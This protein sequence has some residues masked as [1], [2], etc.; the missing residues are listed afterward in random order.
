MSAMNTFSALRRRV[1]STP[2]AA[3][4]W[5]LALS[6]TSTVADAQLRIEIRRGVE[7]PVPI[8]IVPFSWEATP[9]TPLPVDV[10]GVVT[11]DLA[12][13]G[14]FDPLP[15]RDMVSRPNLP[16]QVDIQD[17]Q[18]LEVDVLVIGRV[19]QEGPNRYTVVF[20]LYDILR[21]EQLVGYRLTTSGEELRFTAHRV[22]DMI[23]EELT[24]IP[25]VFSTR[26]AYISEQRQNGT[27]RFRLIVADADGENA[28]IVADSPDPLMSPAW[29]PD[30][31]QLAYVSFEG[32]QAAIYVQTLRTGVR[33]RVSAREGVNGAP[34]F[35]PDGRRLALTLSRDA[36]NL[37][38]FMLDLTTQV[39]IRLTNNPAIDTEP[40]WA[41]DGDSVFFTSDRSGGPQIYRVDARAGA[42]AERVTFEGSYNARARLSPDG[43]QLAVVHRD[44]GNYRIAVVDPRNGL[45][46]VLTS[47]ALDESPSF[48]PNGA[49]I[50]YATRENGRGVLSSVSTDGRIQQQIASVAGDVRE[51]VWSP[52]A[53][54]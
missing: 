28:Q 10:S 54:P 1:V 7:R 48:A 23:Y 13:S 11:A 8:A 51:P 41:A 30:G 32:N 36:G 52:Y 35:S 20:Q 34:A 24:G 9:G 37:D 27:Q 29:S 22:A 39:L 50:I 12:G 16:E 21:G 40:T 15:Q 2:V 45:T 26:V 25:G 38:V 49:V 31:R 44:R 43:Q 5:S 53:R 17:W 6:L 19:L 42:R 4:L 3:L 46:Q 47:G 33:E 18:I 14:R